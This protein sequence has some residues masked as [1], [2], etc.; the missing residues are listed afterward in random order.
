MMKTLILIDVRTHGL[1]VSGCC[2]AV[3]W[4]PHAVTQTTSLSNTSVMFIQ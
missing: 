1:T 2:S 4:L 3:L